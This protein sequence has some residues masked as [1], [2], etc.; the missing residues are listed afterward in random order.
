MLKIRN[1]DRGTISANDII[2]AYQRAFG[3]KVSWW[4]KI[5]IKLMTASVAGC[6]FHLADNYY[7]PVDESLIKQILETDKTNREQY[8]AEDFDCDDFTFKLMG[9]FH[10][11]TRTAAMP[12]FI[13][14]VV[15]T[16]KQAHAVISYYTNNGTVMII[17]P[18]NDNIYSV[19]A[20]WQLILLCG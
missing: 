16:D 13:T 6:P 3:Q 9:I 18:Q 20:G 19:P 15:R 5:L 17:E 1:K 8:V 12:I 4:R 11:D 2:E 14:W 10:Q 7:R